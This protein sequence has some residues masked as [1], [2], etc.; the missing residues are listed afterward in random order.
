MALVVAGSSRKSAA[1]STQTSR[2]WDWHAMVAFR[3]CQAA[4][5]YVAGA[6]FTVYRVPR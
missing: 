5:E 4:S 1:V 3:Y 2:R 6:T